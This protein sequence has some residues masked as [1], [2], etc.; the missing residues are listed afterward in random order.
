MGAACRQPQ[1]V[2]NVMTNPVMKIRDDEGLFEV[3]NMLME[4][5]VRRLAIVD[6]YNE[7]V[8]LVSVNDLIPLLS[9]ELGNIA[10]GMQTAALE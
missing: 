9:V 5:S 6:E 8:G 4:Q 3:T 7:R 10:E 1:A 2:A